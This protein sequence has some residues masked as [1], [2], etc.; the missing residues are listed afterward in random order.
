MQIKLFKLSVFALF[1]AIFAV[2][3]LNGSPAGA[4][5]SGPIASR[6]GAPGELNCTA[7]HMGAAVNSGGGTLT[8]T[9]LP[10]NYSPNQE[11]AVT[12]TL[13]Q[14]GR[15]TFG[16]QLTALDDQNRRAGDLVLTDTART[17]LNSGAIQNNLRQYINHNSAGTNATAP[18]QGSWSFTWRAPA[19]SA[20]RVTFYAAGNAANGNGGN[21]GDFI[22]TANA[23]ITPGTTLGNFASVSAASF[24]PTA[25]V[26]AES[27]LAGFGSG[28]SQNVV[29]ATVT[30]LP[31]TLDGTEVKVKDSANVERSAGLFFVAPTQINYLI[32]AGTANGAA[33]VTVLRGATAVSQGTIK[34]E[35]VSP[36]LFS[37]AANGLGL[38]AAVVLRR[39]GGVDTFEPVTQVVGGQ[40]QAVPIDLGPEGDLV[41]LLG[42]GTGFR[43]VDQSAVSATVG[44]TASTFVST[45][46]VAGLAGL[47]QANIL[48]PRS[49]AGRGLVDVV[50]TASG[51]P[52]NTLQ[53]NIK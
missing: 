38:A 13:T 15:S 25:A 14:T 53:V 37:A 43:T 49:L 35:S 52:A 47:D 46:P 31:T 32:P 40:I 39:R 45:A 6:T 26:T 41:V 7:C 19:Q 12:V 17:I 21:G 11:I 30:P 44:G 28:L 2:Y 20:G 1:C 23:S 34:V 10:Q 4:F 18:G 16:F 24:S 50:F 27:I 42:F 51:K 36:A 9:G 5:S 29:S 22:Y 48:I 3:G 33:T 8:I